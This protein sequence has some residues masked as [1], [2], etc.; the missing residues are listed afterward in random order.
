VKDTKGGE[1]GAGGEKT[2][3]AVDFSLAGPRAPDCDRSSLAG[4]LFLHNRDPTA[5]RPLPRRKCFLAPYR[6]RTKGAPCD[7]E[8]LQTGRV[9][10]RWRFA[11]WP[12]GQGFRASRVWCISQKWVFK[13]QGMQKK[14]SEP[15]R[16][17]RFVGLHSISA[18]LDTKLKYVF[19]VYRFLSHEGAQKPR[20]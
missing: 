4:R 7:E 8:K 5:P 12:Y 2:W 6:S 20:W 15:M 13:A 19:W 18:R 17:G 10:G 16:L 3:I 9:R 14:L 1:S 11:R